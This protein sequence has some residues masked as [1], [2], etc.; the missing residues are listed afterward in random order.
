MNAIAKRKGQETW[1]NQRPNDTALPT[2]ATKTAYIVEA[3]SPTEVKTAVVVASNV[4][5]L[6]YFYL[7]SFDRM[8]KR[9]LTAHSNPNGFVMIRVLLCVLDMEVPT[10]KA[11][12]DSPFKMADHFECDKYKHRNYGCVY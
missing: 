6:L 9:R 1:T 12:L 2:K 3:E 7:C 4:G 5:I 10:S 8:T 11:E